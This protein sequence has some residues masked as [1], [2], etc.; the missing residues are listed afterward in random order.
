MITIE[1]KA[2]TLQ[3]NFPAGTS[4]GILKEKESVIF[5]LDMGG[6]LK[7]AEASFIPGLSMDTLHS[8]MQQLSTIK[9]ETEEDLMQQIALKSNL[10]ALQFALETLKLDFPPNAFS[11]GMEGIPIN[12]L[13]WMG[14]M[15]FMQQQIQQKLQAGFRVIKI[16]IGAISWDQEHSL[17]QQ[18]RSKYA[19]KDVEIRVDAN[20]AFEYKEAPKVLDQLHELDIHSIEQPIKKGQPEFMRKLCA[21]TPV[22]I[23]LDEELIGINDL[24]AKKKLIQTIQPQY[25]ILKPGLLGG[26]HSCEE[27]IQVAKENHVGFWITSALESNIGLNAIAQWTS[28]LG[29]SMP[30][31]LGTGGLYTNNIPSPLEIRGDQLFYNPEKKWDFSSIGW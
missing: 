27:W 8:T 17:L 14:N 30:Q 10:P 18:I 20:G 25:L 16:K 26:F 24:K 11:K 28:Q 15:H 9:L 6:K 5:R 19:K 12:G 1:N 13:I 21:E 4:R 23:A 3:F 2:Y 7:Y 29:V 22:P 31:G